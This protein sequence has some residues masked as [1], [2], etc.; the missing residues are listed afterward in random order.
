MSV[1]SFPD[2]G[3]WGDPRWRGNCS[4]HVYRELFEQLEP[5][6]FCD[7]MVGSGT[8]VEVAQELG[9]EAFGLDLHSGFNVLRDSIIGVI[10]RPVDMCLSHPPYGAMIRY[11]GEVWGDQ[12]HPDDLSRCRNDDDFLDKLQL[13]VLNQREA[14]VPGG[15]YGVIIGD[16][17]SHGRY[18]SYQAEL[19]ARLPAKELRSVM[20]KLQHNVQS[21]RRGYPGLRYPRILHEYVLL[22]EREQGAALLVSLGEVV[23][24][25]DRSIKSTWRNV[26]RLALMELGGES[27]LATLYQLVSEKAPDRLAKNPNWQPKIR[28]VLQRN[29][30]L[31]SRKGRGQW[32]LAA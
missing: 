10:G 23:R 26:V 28:Q 29:P 18:R 20:V 7:P 19:I 31:F 21:A 6:S 22:W 17:R 14:V 30:E 2:R 9:I 25:M 3:P 15:I 11:S 27:D 16:K 8:S 4:G 12:A 1:L 24:R 5:A 13:A 32:A